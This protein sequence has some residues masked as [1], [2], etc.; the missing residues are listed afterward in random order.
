MSSNIVPTHSVKD[1]AGTPRQDLSSQTCW[2]RRRKT[3]ERAAGS[4]PLAS[5]TPRAGSAA[6]RQ[7][8]VVLFFQVGLETSLA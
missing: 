6:I 7:A 2:R 5:P 8:G 4:S 1:A 3:A